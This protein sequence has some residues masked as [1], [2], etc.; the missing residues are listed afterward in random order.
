LQSEAVPK[1]GKF[2]SAKFG[3]T[4]RPSEEAYPGVGESVPGDSVNNV[5]SSLVEFDFSKLSVTLVNRI[6]N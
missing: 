3:S 4:D 2:V 1:V 5:T 6:E